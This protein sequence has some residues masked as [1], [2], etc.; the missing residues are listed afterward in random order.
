MG[1]RL[2]GYKEE[3]VHLGCI[4]WRGRRNG[5]GIEYEGSVKV[6]GGVD[7]IHGAM[8]DGSDP[9]DTRRSLMIA[10]YS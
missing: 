8:G 1:L 6:H 5:G 7:W 9:L 10:H 2:F 4:Y 3:Y